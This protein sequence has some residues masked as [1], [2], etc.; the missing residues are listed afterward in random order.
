M[1][2]S[3]LCE[4]VLLM[5]DTETVKNYCKTEVETN[6]TL[7]RAYYVID[8]LWFIGTQNTLTFT[9]VCPQKQKEVL[10]VNPPIGSVKLNISCTATSRYLNLLHCYNI[11]RKLN[12]QDQ[13]IDNLIMALTSKFEEHSSQLYLM[14]HEQISLQSAKTP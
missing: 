10:I 1:I 11:E 6:S 4:V 8:G 9:V 13:F 12:I 2:P 14:S 5:E 3:K 7:P